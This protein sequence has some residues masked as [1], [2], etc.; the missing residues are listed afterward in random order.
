M[1]SCVLALSSLGPGRGLRGANPGPALWRE[2]QPAALFLFALSDVTW[3][4][5]SWVGCRP[6]LTWRPGLAARP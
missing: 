4:P 6:S 3:E 5:F 2:A 1:L